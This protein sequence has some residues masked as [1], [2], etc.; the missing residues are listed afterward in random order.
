MA[1]IHAIMAILKKITELK[2]VISKNGLPMVEM[3]GQQHDLVGKWLMGN[4][5]IILCYCSIL[6]VLKC[7][8]AHSC[9]VYNKIFKQFSYRIRKNFRG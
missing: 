5:Y 2:N 6:Y 9:L 7:S 3:I 1:I 4:C 8:L